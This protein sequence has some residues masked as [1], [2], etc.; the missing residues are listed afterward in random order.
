MSYLVA[1]TALKAVVAD[2]S[3]IRYVQ[4]GMV[5]TAHNTPLAYFEADTGSR[6]Q[7]G[8]QTQNYYRPTL[9][10]AVDMQDNVASELL[11]IPFINSIPAAIDA[12]ARDNAIG[13]GINWAKVTD[14]RVEYKDIAEKRHHCLVFVL[15]V[16]EKG[17][18]GSGI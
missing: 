16:L 12:A 17:T 14:W 9:T 13:V 3:G 8:Q 2:V 18:F 7:A 15:E 6:A 4:N 11:L 1:I 5:T 10:V